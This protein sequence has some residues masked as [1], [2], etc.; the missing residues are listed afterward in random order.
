MPV[1]PEELKQRLEAVPQSTPDE[2]KE[3][4][5]EPPAPPADPRG[6][7]SYTFAFKDEIGGKALEG[8]FTNKVPSVGE[9]RMIGVLRAQLANGVPY[10]QLDDFT[11]EVNLMVAHMTVSLRAKPE[12]AKNL[13][14]LDVSVIQAL[15]GEVAAHETTFR[16]RRAVKK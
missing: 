3:A 5:S 14:L 9:T 12:W 1:S 4:A 10:D 16:L 7:V 15:Y 2:L 11:K 8:S 13:D 6:N